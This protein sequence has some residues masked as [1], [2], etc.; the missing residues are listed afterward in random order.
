VPVFQ[1][2]FTVGNEIKRRVTAPHRA[3]ICI[4]EHRHGPLCF[5][6]S[7]DEHFRVFGVIVKAMPYA[8]AL[9][10]EIVTGMDGVQALSGVQQG[11]EVHCAALGKR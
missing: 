9:H 5:K 4:T 11:R 6:L 1:D 10:C 3:Q 8:P 2:Q 7:P